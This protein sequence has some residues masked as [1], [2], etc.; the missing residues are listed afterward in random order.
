MF[1]EQ[2]KNTKQTPWQAKCG[3]AAFQSN[4]TVGEIIIWSTAYG[5]L[6]LRDQR[7]RKT[8]EALN[9]FA[10]HWVKHVIDSLQLSQNP[11][12]WLLQIG[13]MPIRHTDY[14]CSWS[15]LVMCIK[16]ICPQFLPTFLPP[17]ARTKSCQKNKRQDCRPP[18]V[19]NGHQ[20]HQQ[21]A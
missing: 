15:R 9:W 10:W 1:T 3:M 8:Q 21:E 18:Q 4:Q 20:N 17:L 7:S 5:T 2:P 13:S 12:L 16:Y 11:E 19:W 6:T 14:G